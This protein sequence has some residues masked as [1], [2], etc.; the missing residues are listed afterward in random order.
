MASEALKRMVDRLDAEK[1]L[2][3]G[4]Y[5]TN[6]AELI[7][8]LQEVTPLVPVSIQNDKYYN[9]TDQAIGVRITVGLA[10]DRSEIEP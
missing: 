4:G 6:A 9:Y 1:K 10:L 7:E 2:G 3:H 8:I 5:V